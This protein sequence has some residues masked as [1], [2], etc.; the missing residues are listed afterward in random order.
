MR[1]EFV[2]SRWRLKII[3]KFEKI[4]ILFNDLFKCLE[5]KR[6]QVSANK[7]GHYTRNVSV[8]EARDVKMLQNCVHCTHLQQKARKD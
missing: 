5:N 7:N 2:I 3:I 6:T 8:T 4:H 1:L